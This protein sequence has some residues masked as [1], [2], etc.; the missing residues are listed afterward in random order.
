MAFVREIHINWLRNSCNVSSILELTDFEVSYSLLTN[1]VYLSTSFTDKMAC[2]PNWPLESLLIIWLS[3]TVF[4]Y[5]SLFGGCVSVVKWI[6]LTGK[7]S[8]CLI[9]ANFLFLLNV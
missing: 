2:I 3:D 6:C 7:N 9:G 4:L 5:N 1:E 8:V